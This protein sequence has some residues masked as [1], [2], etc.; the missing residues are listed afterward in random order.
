MDSGSSR[1][2][3]SFVLQF[4]QGQL[5]GKEAYGGR[6]GSQGNRGFGRPLPL[7]DFFTT[8]ARG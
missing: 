4:H 3:G 1:G 2:D 8:V 7:L 5:E 6:S